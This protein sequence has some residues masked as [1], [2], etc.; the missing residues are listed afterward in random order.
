[1]GR[2]RALVTGATGYIGSNLVQGLL[3]ENWAVD[4]LVRPNSKL[5]ALKSSVG[6]IGIHEYDG[7]TRSMFNIVAKANPDTIFHIASLFLAQH[8]LADVESLVNSNILFA[9]QMVDAMAANGVKQLINTGTSW[10]HFNNNPYNPVNLYAA[11]KQAFEAMLAYYIE[12]HGLKVSTLVIFDTYGPNDPRPKL[13]SVLWRAALT[14]QTLC[15]SPGDQ[16][17]DLVH[18]EDVIRAFI[19]AAEQ[20]PNQPAGH[21]RYGISSGAP[22]SLRDL[23]QSFEAATKTTIPIK[24]G[25]RPYRSRE[26]MIPWDCFSRLPRWQPK[27]AFPAGISGTRPPQ[28]QGG[29]G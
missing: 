3:A 29:L 27:I 2:R 20:L 23:V 9:T 13:I 19:L 15:M 6:S 5:D 21:A 17:I 7:S 8:K 1:M 11:T 12:A 18:I 14:Q 28:Q 26:V 16:L 10:Q 25:G 4:I 22:M 24:W